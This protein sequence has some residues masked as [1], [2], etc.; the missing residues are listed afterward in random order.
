MTS[1]PSAAPA[2]SSPPTAHAVQ[3]SCALRGR[4]P[5]TPLKV[6]FQQN[7]CW[8]W[9]SRARQIQMLDGIFGS[10]RVPCQGFLAGRGGALAGREACA[11]KR[12]GPSLCRN[13]SLSLGGP[14]PLLSSWL[15]FKALIVLRLPPRSFRSQFSTRQGAKSAYPELQLSSDPP[16]FTGRLFPVR[17][18]LLGCHGGALVPAMPHY[19]PAVNP[20]PV[21]FPALLC[22]PK[23]GQKTRCIRRS[24][25]FPMTRNA[26]VLFMQR[27]ASPTP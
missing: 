3:L 20:P 6:L 19:A 26:M 2:L 11:G 10:R 15:E 23:P 25:P 1:G 27:S 5:P 22:A 8:K 24:I 13:S 12:G 9:P 7:N 18:G 4:F 16:A 21:H 17:R 14:P